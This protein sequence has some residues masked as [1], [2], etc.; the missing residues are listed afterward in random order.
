MK[1]GAFLF[2]FFRQACLN[3]Q[4]NLIKM[5]KVFKPSLL[6]HVGRIKVGSYNHLS[7]RNFTCCRPF[8]FPSNLLL[9]GG[10]HSATS[11]QSNKQK[12]MSQF[13]ASLTDSKQGISNE[14]VDKLQETMSNLSMTNDTD[15][16]I[17]TDKEGDDLFGVDIHYHKSEIF[18]VEG[19]EHPF[20]LLDAAMET[21]MSAQMIFTSEA[22]R[23]EPILTSGQIYP[24]LKSMYKASVQIE[25]D[26]KM[27]KSK[28]VEIELRLMERFPHEIRKDRIPC[29][30]YSE[31][32]ASFDFGFMD[33]SL[34]YRGC[35]LV[36]IHTFKECLLSI[37]KVIHSRGSFFFSISDSK[38]EKK[39]SLFNQKFKVLTVMTDMSNKLL[40]ERQEH[41]ETCDSSFIPFSQSINI[42]SIEELKTV[43]PSSFLHHIGTFFDPSVA[44]FL[45][46][47][48]KTTASFGHSHEVPNKLKKDL[49]FY[50]AS[51]Y[52]LVN[53]KVAAKDCA[54]LFNNKTI[55]GS[56][57][58]NIQEDNE[59][60]KTFTYL[61]YPYIETS[62][63][64]NIPFP[65]RK[66]VDSVGLDIDGNE[67][68][69]VSVTK[70]ALQDSSIILFNDTSDHDRP[71]LPSNVYY[72]E[73]EEDISE[74][75]EVLDQKDPIVYNSSAAVL[76]PNISHDHLEE[77]KEV[78]SPTEKY[79]KDMQERMKN[80]NYQ[81]IGLRLLS[82]KPL[83]EAPEYISSHQQDF[84]Y[85]SQVVRAINSI[86]MKQEQEERK[87]DG[88]VML[89]IHGG[90][91]IAMT[92]FGHEVY[93]RKWCSAT[94]IPII[95]VDYRRTPEH[96]YPVALEECYAAYCWLINN[97]EKI[98][99]APLKKLIVAGDSAGG[100]LSLTVTM[101]AIHEGIRTPDALVLSY[102]A[103]YMDFSPSAS[104][105]V[106]V[107]EPLVNINF[108]RMCGEL[109]C[110]EK[111]EPGLNPFI[112][113]SMASDGL[114][115]K[116]PPTYFNV[117]SL[118][119]L[120]DDSVYLAKRIA[121]NNGGKVKVNIYDALGHGYL[122]MVDVS[123][124]AR[125]ASAH[126]CE[127][128][129]GILKHH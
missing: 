57:F 15:P 102:P 13:A 38:Y 110:T 24:L 43:D 74:G 76:Y 85:L 93:L 91:F 73:D 46:L 82:T 32:M 98:L 78:D 44:T 49:I 89:H 56:G 62:Q 121:K 9:G 124:A 2:T 126:I 48:V 80:H 71:N 23:Y 26:L 35:F 70:E 47:I 58:W 59:I 95:S 6:K 10:P 111:D 77:V 127:W 90:G 125:T 66:I 106:S 17:K 54:D 14:N 33:T 41:I 51:A 69:Y 117:G 61:G 52:Y 72:S 68:E 113:P 100:N 94:H 115:Q 5:K 63:K 103:T 107:I 92:S 122:N 16:F 22:K 99:G 11:I 8:F 40:A 50:A 45:S 28:I 36:L 64:F 128:I 116:F 114:L 105:M 1:W 30:S 20:S 119:P 65:G 29:Q 67:F 27:L 3:A 12:N 53:P 37:N 81:E 118:D 101:R 97:C 123:Q 39:L 60:I 42:N 21:V 7:V 75:E 96:K 34:H 109:Y 25:S 19:P 112:S 83:S 108:L 31:E 18:T 84:P 55:A 87:F 86:K 79:Y 88:T 120:F 4:P 104:R 129:M